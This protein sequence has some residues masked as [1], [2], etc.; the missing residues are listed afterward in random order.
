MT[1]ANT[2]CELFD[3]QEG[4]GGCHELERRFTVNGVREIAKDQ[5][6][7]DAETEPC[8]RQ[9]HE[10]QRDLEWLRFLAWFTCEWLGVAAMEGTDAEDGQDD[11]ASPKASVGRGEGN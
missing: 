1:Q 4:R 3:E 2:P 6:W 10:H 8:A 9:G 5:S 7:E 11:R